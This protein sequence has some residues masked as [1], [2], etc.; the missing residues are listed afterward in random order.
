MSTIWKVCS[1]MHLILGRGSFCTNYYIIRAWH[2]GDQPMALLKCYGTQSC[3]DSCRQLVCIVGCGVCYLPLKN[4]SV[5][6]D[7]WV[8]KSACHVKADPGSNPG[9]RTFAACLSLPFPVYPLSNKGVYVT[10]K[11]TVESLITGEWQYCVVCTLWLDKSVARRAP[12]LLQLS[13]TVQFHP[14]H[15]AGLTSLQHHSQYHL[16]STLLWRI[17][18]W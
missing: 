13:V 12:K 4:Q 7:S 1:L 9:Q 3:F 6:A 17:W 18:H 8:V 16:H 15:R 11:C 2:G 5:R 10:V 14:H